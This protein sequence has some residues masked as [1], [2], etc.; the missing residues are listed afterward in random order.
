MD[1]G[2][3]KDKQQDHKEILDGIAEMSGSLDL[4]R[5][6]NKRSSNIMNVSGT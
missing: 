4:M 5:E 2:G 3:F 1:V 6:L